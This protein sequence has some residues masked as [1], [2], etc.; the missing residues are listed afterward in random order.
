MVTEVSCLYPSWNTLPTK[1]PCFCQRTYWSSG[2]D[3]AYFANRQKSYTET[4]P[5]D[6]IDCG[7]TK[8]YLRAED[9]KARLAKQTPD[10]HIEPCTFCMACDRSYLESAKGVRSPAETLAA[11]GV[12]LLPL[13]SF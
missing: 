10:C 1:P 6:H 11:K 9:K 8:A 3:P 13:N 5:W 4:L 2:V 7:V 12:T